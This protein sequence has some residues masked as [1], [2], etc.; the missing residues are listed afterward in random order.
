[1][2]N[3]TA[4]I[5]ENIISNLM[6]QFFDSRDNQF[7]N[8][9]NDMRLSAETGYSSIN[10]SSPVD[11]SQLDKLYVKYEDFLGNVYLITWE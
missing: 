9:S 4:V 3:G 8:Q 7:Y 2:H 1:L 10:F 6:V 5:P 11:I